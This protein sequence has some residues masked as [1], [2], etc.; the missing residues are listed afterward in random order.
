M[1]EMPLKAASINRRLSMETKKPFHE[2]VAEGLI[3]KL[4]QGT[5][6]FQMP[7]KPGD[8][9]GVMPFNP[10]TGKRYKGVNAIHLMA[11]GRADQRWLTYKQAAALG[12]QVRK[13]EK[14]T[15]I[16]YWKFEEEQAK[17]D[18]NNKPVLDGNGD[19]VKVRVRLERPKMFM[20]NVFNAEQIDG[21]SDY[22]RP[23]QTWNS[24]ERA[25]QILAASGADI[26]H[27]GDNAY[28]SPSLDRIQMPGKE[29]FG[30]AT[31]YY[32]VAFHELGHWTGH[33]SRLD[34]DLGH[35]F[36]SEMYAKEEL[37][38]EIASMILGAE[39]DLGYDPGQ[40]A[41]YVESWIKVL[42]NDPLEI[43]RA[44]ADA[45]KIQGFVLGLEQEQIQTQNESQQLA[46][47][48]PAPVPEAWT[49]EACRA[50]DELTAIATGEPNLGRTTHMARRVSE[51][52]Q[53]HFEPSAR[54][55]AFIEKNKAAIEET[56]QWILEN[57]RL[58]PEV[59]AQV[60]ETVR[61][62]GG[63]TGMFPEQDAEHRAY[64]AEM[65]AKMEPQ[66]T[67]QVATMQTPRAELPSVEAE[68]WSLKAF[69]RP[70]LDQVARRMT[71]EQLDTFYRVL[72]N[73]AEV[74]NANEFWTRRPEA[75]EA[76][77]NNVD[78][79]EE[80][81]FRAREIVE[82]E[83]ERRRAVAKRE[84]EQAE[85]VNAVPAVQPKLSQNEQMVATALRNMRSEPDLVLKESFGRLLQTTSAQALGY[86]LPGDWSG[87]TQVTGIA[88]DPDGEGVHMTEGNETPEFYG[89]YARNEKG[90]A[91]WLADYQTEA[92]ALSQA[93]KLAAI[94]SHAA[95]IPDLEFVTNQ[96]LLAEQILTLEAREAEIGVQSELDA[97][98]ETL[99]GLRDQVIVESASQGSRPQPP[100]ENT[101]IDVPFKDKAEAKELGAKW[102]RQQTSW[103][104]PK[105][106]DQAA[107]AKWLN[108]APVESN[109]LASEAPKASPVPKADREYLAVPYGEREAAKAAGAMWDKSN[110][111]WYVGRDADTTLLARWKLDKVKN[112]QGPAMDLREEFTEA[113]KAVGLV[114]QQDKYGDHPIMDGN[115]Y[116]L[117]VVGGAK[118]AK[119]G[120]YRVFT[121]GHPAG[122]IINNKSG[123]SV[124]W[125]SK[126][127]TLSDEQKAAMQAEAASKLQAR[128]AELL[129]THERVAEK[130]TRNMADLV[131]IVE[132]TPYLAS[133]GIL[134]SPGVLTDKAG[135]ETVIPAVDAEGKQWTAQYIQKDGTKR[136]AK[137]GRKEGCFHP[138]GGL[139]AIAAAPALV[140]A[141]G[142]ATARSLATALE[143]G[144][145]AA[146][147][148]GNLA[149]VVKELHQRFPDKPVIVAGDDDVHL[150]LTLGVNV[151]RSKA[152]EAAR[153]A[154]GKAIFP[155]FAPGEV[156]YPS[157]V[158]PITPQLYRAH[159]SAAHAFKDMISAE[160]P[161]ARN[162]E[163]A[164]ELKAAMLSEAQLAALEKMKRLTDF[165]DLQ[166]KSSLGQDGLI[167]QV[168]NAVAKAIEEHQERQQSRQLQ[169]TVQST[170]V[171]PKPRR[172][173]SR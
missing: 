167:R 66:K 72:G 18:E 24:L 126:G 73:M 8:G 56:R 92:E 112:E 103:Y 96:D 41:A 118:G 140:V 110:K 116:R 25:D 170:V 119:D 89:L 26:R 46:T 90:L 38:A 4:K 127:Y 130:V 153:G 6:P 124:K 32:R 151:G 67:G 88:T 35:P 76:M 107:F 165:N 11:Q 97:L 78:L 13:G 128:E 117:P 28:Y 7:W 156:V 91:I 105:G 39:L 136:F 149:A 123:V 104:I 159:L 138:V 64:L 87:A 37:R 55:K 63:E 75:M 121:D 44:A 157:D 50:F 98:R 133:K 5:A 162:S 148:S 16:Q 59:K 154:G 83:L 147:D 77:F 80:N 101:Y 27:G 84:Q 68:D 82:D 172:S 53:M 40:H 99:Q 30:T 160:G 34:R 169:N 108:P 158:P 95:V 71:G 129:K 57:V 21:L 15:P 29:Q 20:A 168:K 14:S 173:L 132:P 49:H 120:F 31:D 125:K 114:P 42:K 152:Q 3:E 94:E 61:D 102:D 1:N 58:N 86:E 36:G 60:Y 155:T 12:A 131:A 81:I 139:D 9:G 65:Q 93:A 10:S 164:A 141:E 51:Y 113:L 171:D 69:E 17:R 135:K 54:E 48:Q 109:Q 33:P 47:T 43:F 150:V 70:D 2:V 74:S 115:K 106:V 146:F 145:V 166:T 137:D 161:E 144:T 85:S 62:L 45:E 19:P 142:Y 22:Q 52:D 79:V 111:S 143:F 23:A 134:P 100:A 122:A 163:R